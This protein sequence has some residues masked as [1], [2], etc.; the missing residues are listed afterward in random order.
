M[1]RAL[2]KKSKPKKDMPTHASGLPKISKIA[3]RDGS[4]FEKEFT[5]NEIEKINQLPNADDL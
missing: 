3:A 4:S 1:A 5:P 2:N